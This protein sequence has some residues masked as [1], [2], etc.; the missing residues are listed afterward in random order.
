M[1]L[2][3]LVCHHLSSVI[4]LITVVIKDLIF[5]LSGSEFEATAK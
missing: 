5:V 3:S 2:I 1:N 4:I